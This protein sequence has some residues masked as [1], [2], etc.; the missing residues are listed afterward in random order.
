MGRGYFLITSGTFW[1]PTGG[2][3]VYTTDSIWA[4]T[5]EYDGELY[6]IGEGNEA[7]FLRNVE[8]AA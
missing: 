6:Q 4:D 7:V 8:E 3:Y 2:H 5:I 1:K